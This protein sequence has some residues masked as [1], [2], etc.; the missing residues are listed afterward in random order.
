MQQGDCRTATQILADRLN[1]QWDSEL[2][3]LYGDCLQGE[4]RGQLEQAERWLPQH[5]DDAGLLLTL[6]KLCLHQGLWSRAQS[7][8]DASNSLTPSSAAYNALGQLAEKLQHKEEASRNFHKAMN[9]TQSN[10][11]SL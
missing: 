7:Y 9:L 5:P 6:G 4:S 11:G 1:T 3:T 8:L 10:S 2:V